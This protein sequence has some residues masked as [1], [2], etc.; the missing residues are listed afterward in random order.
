MRGIVHFFYSPSAGHNHACNTHDYT[1]ARVCLL[2]F[3]YHSMMNDLCQSS[4]S[5][6]FVFAI[7]YAIGHKWLDLASIRAIRLTCRALSGLPGT[8]AAGSPN[9]DGFLEAID[10]ACYWPL[11]A[12][13]QI[14]DA[15]RPHRTKNGKYYGDQ[16][17]STYTNCIC[18]TEVTKCIS[19]NDIYPGHEFALTG[20]RWGQY[21]YDIFPFLDLLSRCRLIAIDRMLRWLRDQIH[22]MDPKG[23]DIVCGRRGKTTK[24]ERLELCINHVIGSFEIKQSGGIFVMVNVG[25]TKGERYGDTIYLASIYYPPSWK[26]LI[27]VITLECRERNWD[28]ISRVG[29]LNRTLQRELTRPGRGGIVY[30]QWSAH[31]SI[32]HMINSDYW[33][34]G[35]Y[36]KPLS[37]RGRLRVPVYRLA[38]FNLAF[39]CKTLLD[40]LRWFNIYQDGQSF[41]DHNYEIYAPHMSHRTLKTCE[42]RGW[43]HLI[44]PGSWVEYDK[45]VGAVA[46][47][48]DVAKKRI[49]AKRSGDEDE[50]GNGNASPLKRRQ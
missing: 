40:T 38:S 50:D 5:R 19:G 30:Y 43:R 27:D 16:P 22:D 8:M 29:S 6:G 42:K 31:G 21:T 39:D 11:H 47:K 17:Y 12:V 2:P 15:I 9:R 18:P 7:K 44:E 25:S 10:W 35:G 13:K 23:G 48:L 37:A 34:K 49:R 33:A 41:F 24:T 14:A 45:A 28:D 20:V 46:E 4:T 36:A 32:Q 26:I 1:R 3:P